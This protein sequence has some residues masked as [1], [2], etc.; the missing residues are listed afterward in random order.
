ME[1]GKHSS[2]PDWDKRYREGFYDGAEEPH[3]LLRRYRQEIPPGRTL[4][5]AMGTGRDAVF[6]ASTGLDAWGVD[7]SREAVGLAARRAGSTGWGIR[8]VRADGEALPFKAGSFSAVTVFYFLIREKM[9]EIADLVRP[10]GILLYETFLLRQNLIDRERN[11]DY[12]L[13]DGELISFFPGFDL[14]CYEEGVVKE[15]GKQKAIARFAG[16]KR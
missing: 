5:V 12:L 11:P 15:K 13:L 6:L 14:L 10:G 16:R 3:E 9:R 1:M 8:I 7:S 2:V 4:D